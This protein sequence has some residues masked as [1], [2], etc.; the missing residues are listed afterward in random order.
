[1]TGNYRTISRGREERVKLNRK[2]LY[3]FAIF[4]INNERLIIL[5]NLEGI[6]TNVN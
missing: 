2:I 1:M 6:A 5:T 3:R 4:T